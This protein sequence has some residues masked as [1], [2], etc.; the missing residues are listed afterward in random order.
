MRGEVELGCA[1]VMC[2]SNARG[3]RAAWHRLVPLL[4][5]I[6]VLGGWAGLEEFRRSW[7]RSDL[8]EIVADRGRRGM[9]RER[10]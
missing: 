5:S 2:V 6:W 3:A 9:G 7:G 4:G 10:G 8:A 1:R